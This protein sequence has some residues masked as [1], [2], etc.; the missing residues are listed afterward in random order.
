MKYLNDKKHDIVVDINVL[1]YITTMHK[2]APNLTPRLQQW[3]SVQVTY[4]ST[5]VTFN[6]KSIFRAKEISSEFFFS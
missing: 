2:D 6:S 5:I 4:K 3:I 1:V